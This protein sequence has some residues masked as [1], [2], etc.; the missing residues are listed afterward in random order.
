MRVLV[1]DNYDSFTYNLVQYL[2]ELGAEVEVVRNDH[3]SV[4]ELL[5]RGYDRVIVSPGPCT[6]DDSGISIEVLRRFP[7][8]GIPVLGVCLGHQALGQ[9]YGGK[10][11][12]HKPV[13]GKTEPIEHD[14]RTVFAGLPSPLTVGRYHS[15][16]VDEQLPD[17]LEVSARG[18]GVIMALRHKTLPAEGIQFHPES[19][20]TDQGH[21]LLRNFLFGGKAVPD[22]EPAAI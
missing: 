14:G 4:E 3:A 20:L 9:A 15:L 1:V 7:A 22:A 16:V 8:A 5:L 17:V 12:R 19:V 13:H 11:I 2:G 6:P 18:G 10:V 21:D